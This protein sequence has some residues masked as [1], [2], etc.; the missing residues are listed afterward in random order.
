MNIGLHPELADALQNHY[1]R[2]LAGLEEEFDIKIDVIASRNLRRAEQKVEW[3][4]ASPATSA[5][6]RGRSR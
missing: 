1:R 3:F 6:R 4:D 5:R 2:E